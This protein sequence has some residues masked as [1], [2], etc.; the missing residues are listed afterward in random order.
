MILRRLSAALAASL[1]A[2]PSLALVI[3]A[4]NTT[5]A[6]GAPT[7]VTR[8]FCINPTTGIAESCSG[9]GGGGGSVSA[10]ATAANPSYSEGS[11]TSAL[12]MDLSGRLRVRDDLLTA[13]I[14]ATSDTAYSGSGSG[15]QVA[16]LKSM[17]AQLRLIVSGISDTSATH[18]IIDSSALPTG[19]ATAANQT[20]AN[21]SLSTIATNTGTSATNTGTTATG[22]GAPA[23]SAYTGSGSASVI[24]ALK[25]IYTAT[26]AAPAPSAVSGDVAAA[27]T[28]SG[29]PVK[30]GGVYNTTQ[31]SYTNGQRGNIQITAK[32]FLLSTNVFAASNGGDA[33]SNALSGKAQDAGGSAVYTAIMP[34]VF[35]GSTWDRTRGDTNGAWTVMAP[36]AA[37]SVATTTTSCTTA[38]SSLVAKASSGNLYGFQATAGTT[39]GYVM[40]F[41]ATSAPADGTVTP[42]KCYAVAA[43]ATRDVKFEPPVSFS[44]GITLVFSTGTD[45]FT[46]TASATVFMSGDVK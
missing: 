3:S 34:W 33:V 9:G 19:A 41:N 14:G 8:I 45:C 31:P 46:K 22:I 6:S 38:C 12:S 15:T 32:G 7:V 27:A 23:D 16:I 28:D 2:F 40:A 43:S 21:S 26:L 1:M 39:A 30:I 24:A 11:T 18:S 37:T 10:T 5:L 13:V 25:G 44:T 20:T 17:D 35:N 36:S 29:N 4:P 42:L